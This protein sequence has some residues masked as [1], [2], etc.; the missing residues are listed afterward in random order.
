MRHTI[1]LSEL[2]LSVSYVQFFQLNNNYEMVCMLLKH[3]LGLIV[4]G[5]TITKAHETLLQNQ[6]GRLYTTQMFRRL[7]NLDCAI[8][9][10]FEKHQ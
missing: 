2:S 7:L 4:V 9:R 3:C 6:P 1:S 5:L 8:R 10:F